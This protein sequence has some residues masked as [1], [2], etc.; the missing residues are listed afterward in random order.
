MIEVA[1]VSA[2]RRRAALTLHALAAPDRE[3]LLEQLPPTERASL[4]GLLVELR[5]L[6]IPADAEVIR[7]ALAEVAPR[8]DAAEA[9][10][11]AVVLTR[12]VESL[13]G[14]LLSLLPAAQREAVLAQWPRE[15]EARPLP[16][17][18]PAWT[19]KLQDAVLK[20]WRDLAM[21]AQP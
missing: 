21:E 16:V 12:E 19:P 1:E 3:W 13:R 14:I 18:K 7:S 11:L 8:V 9:Q 10:A 15:L 6:G 4:R 17:A 20:S 5:E 2:G